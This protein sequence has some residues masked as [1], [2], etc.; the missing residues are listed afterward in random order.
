ME[1]RISRI[2]TGFIRM[3]HFWGT[4]F[5]QISPIRVLEPSFCENRRNKLAKFAGKML[6]T[7]G[8]TFPAD[9]ADSGFRTF[10][11]RKSAEQIGRICG[12]NVIYLILSKYCR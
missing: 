2:F 8:N 6:S 9:F 10:M 5:P 3:F 7:L 4:L 12:K 1:V 11:L